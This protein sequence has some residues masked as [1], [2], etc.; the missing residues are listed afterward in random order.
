[1]NA[2]P[3]AKGAFRKPAAAVVEE[4]AVRRIIVADIDIEIAVALDIGHRRAGSPR[5]TI[6]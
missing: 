3:A 6:A 5:G 4:K 1:M 2:R